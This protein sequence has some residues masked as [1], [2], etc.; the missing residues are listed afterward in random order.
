MAGQRRRL[1]ADPFHE[2]AVAADDEGVVVDEVRAETGPQH[3]LGEPEPDPVGEALPERPVVT[4]MPGQVV[5][6]GMAGRPA[7]QLP[8]LAQV[9]ELDAVARSGRASS[10]GGCR[11]GRR[12][13][14][15]GPGRA[16]SG[17]LGS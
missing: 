11:R 5:D 12:T 2:V 10:T 15:T 4:S 6:F 13:A 17:S 1:V 9:L 3:P 8:E 14:R 7:V 16:R